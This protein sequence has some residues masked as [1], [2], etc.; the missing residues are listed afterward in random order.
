MKLAENAAKVCAAKR[1]QDDFE[2]LAPVEDSAFPD[3][4]ST[5]I[6]LW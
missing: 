1:D 3:N 4:D 2:N 6:D 5:V